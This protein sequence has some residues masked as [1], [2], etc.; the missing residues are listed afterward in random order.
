MKIRVT[1]ILRSI[2]L[3]FIIFLFTSTK[4]SADSANK[5]I[6]IITD[7]LDFCTIK[8]LEINYKISLGIMNTRTANVF[9]NSGESYF[10]TIATGRRV[11]LEKG[12]FKGVKVD[13]QG[14]L[15]VDGY[16][17]ILGQLNKSYT[18]FSKKMGFLADSFIQN[19][20]QVGYI[21]ND[22]SS[23]IAADK[24]GMIYHGHP[25]IKYDKD[26]LMEKTNDTLKES[27]LLVVSYDINGDSNRLEVLEEYLNEFSKYSI[28]V[29][30]GKVSGDMKDIRNS[31]LVPFLYHNPNKVSGMLSSDSTKR[32]GLITNMDVFPELGDIYHMEVHTDIGH[33]IDSTGNQES[34]EELTEK[35]KNNFEKVLNLIVIKYIFHGIIIITQL[36]IIYDICRKKHAYYDRYNMLMNGIMICIFLSILLGIFHLGKSIIL[37]FMI[38]LSLA[39]GIIVFMKRKKIDSSIFFPIGTNILLLIA[40]YFQ[41]DMIYHSFYGFTNI[42][43]GGRFYGLNNESMGILLVTSITTFFWIKK[44]IKN[45]LALTIGLVTYFS[46]VILALSDYYGSNFGGYLTS[47]VL[48]FMLLYTI[49]NKRGTKKN[50]F[51]LITIGIGIFIIS[52]LGELGNPTAGHV[53]NLIFRVETLGIYEVV[54]MVTK[55]IKQ[56]VLTVI[57]PPWSIVFY[58]QIYFIRKF[59]LNRKVLI[60]R[61]KEKEADIGLELF[62]I[63]ISSIFVF[64][65]NDTGIVAFVYMNTYLIAQLIFLSGKYQYFVK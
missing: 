31:T 55:K 42:V 24:K 59:I 17:D 39:I 11:E 44:K 33:K 45:K 37:Y 25:T 23:L 30:P 36:Y 16:K 21:G 18:G 14:N 40:V 64:V 51:I 8:R 35:I 38:I 61:V 19:G 6:L 15:G 34:K 62:I 27:D 20:V 60:Q 54:D 13:D 7:Q 57:S 4:A 43:S 1:K 26:W 52:F 32:E 2:F 10:M 65:L 56:L 12:L 47:I 3:V 5:T 63:L 46:V 50:L 29:F 41:P 9:D 48:F 28:M 53:K 22:V 58:C 49:L